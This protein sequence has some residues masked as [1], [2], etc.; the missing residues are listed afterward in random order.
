MN[1]TLEKRRA[2]VIQKLREQLLRNY[3]QRCHICGHLIDGEYDIDHLVPRER[4]GTD[5]ISNLAP[6]HVSCNRSKQNV[7]AHAP[8]AVQF[9]L[10]K[11]GGTLKEATVHP[12]PVA[13][14][15]HECKEW[16]LGEVAHDPSSGMPTR[17]H[18]WLVDRLRQPL[19][20]TQTQQKFLDG[21]KVVGVK[22]I[23]S[24]DGFTWVKKGD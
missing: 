6:A 8:G 21:C 23:P 11:K 9:S 10:F 17:I 20:Y 18:H 3:E 7:A 24:D 14:L 2:R 13:D 1:K 22:A 4:G 5:A 19:T 12:S 16:I 15:E